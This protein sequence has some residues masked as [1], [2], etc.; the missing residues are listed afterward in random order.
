LRTNRSGFTT[1]RL[2][3]LDETGENGKERVLEVAKD[4]DSWRGMGVRDRGNWRRIVVR[5]ALARAIQ[6]FEDAAPF[7]PRMRDY[8]P[9]STAQSGT[10][11]E[12]TCLY[13]T[14]LRPLLCLSRV[15]IAAGPFRI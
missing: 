3:R 10:T 4:G 12:I 8:N 13:D 15:Q 5:Q 7:S 1:V 2:R 11:A 6:M 14:S 9:R